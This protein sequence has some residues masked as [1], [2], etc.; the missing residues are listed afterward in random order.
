MVM[1]VK[2]AV[3]SAVSA[4]MEEMFFLEPQ[5]SDFLWSKVRV[6][7][8]CT[9]SVTMAFPRTLLIQAAHGLF[10]EQERIREQ[11]LWDTLAEVVNTVAGRIMSNLLPPDSTFRLS[12]PESGTGWPAKDGEPILYMTDGGGFV[13]MTDG[14]ADCSE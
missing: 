8:P 5:A 12:V 1:D 4:T 14:L 3:H 2:E 13:V 11:M 10:G 9:G 6:L 7:E